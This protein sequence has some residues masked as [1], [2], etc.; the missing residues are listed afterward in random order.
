[1][2]IQLRVVKNP[3]N[4]L[5][6]NKIIFGGFFNGI[7]SAGKGGINGHPRASPRPFSFR[8]LRPDL[9]NDTAESER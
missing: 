6:N 4:G 2:G 8:E 9:V 3:E 7:D 5:A 1:M